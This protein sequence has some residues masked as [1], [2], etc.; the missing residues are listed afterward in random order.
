MSRYRVFQPEGRLAALAARPGGL[1]REAAVARAAA[2]LAGQREPALAALEGWITAL[3][4][5]VA[6]ARP[7]GF[8]DLRRLADRII[9]AAAAYEMDALAA[10]AR[11]LADLVQLF[12][13]RGAVQAA[14]LGLH[15]RALR[16]LAPVPSARE[17]GLVL[18]ELDRLRR[19]CAEG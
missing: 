11:R 4:Q 19:H 17:A 12:E 18:Q 10:G 6:D 16:L 2:R 7:D 14:A 1:S 15:V 3:E 13:R 8:A 5:H 9:A